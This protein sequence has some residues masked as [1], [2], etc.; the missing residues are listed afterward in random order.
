MANEAIKNS[1]MKSL[2]GEGDG[3]SIQAAQLKQTIITNSLLSD[4]LNIQVKQFR[5]EEKKFAFEKKQLSKQ[6]LAAQSS[7][8]KQQRGPQP[9]TG[10]G[11][12]LGK[13]FNWQDALLGLTVGGLMLGPA[14]ADLL[15]RELE[16]AAEK[17]RG[18]IQKAVDRTSTAIDKAYKRADRVWQR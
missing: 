9:K 1:L 3:K 8:I 5:L 2:S 7:L 16:K 14:A 15:Q 17:A 18:R 12:F 6:K 4:M 10:K 11:S 13:G